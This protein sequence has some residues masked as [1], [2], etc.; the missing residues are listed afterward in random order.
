[1]HLSSTA[2]GAFQ[3]YNTNLFHNQF[4]RLTTNGACQINLLPN[5]WIARSHAEIPSL[6]FNAAALLLSYFLTVKLIKVIAQ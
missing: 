4:T 5:Y 2:W 6:A 1:M 3:I